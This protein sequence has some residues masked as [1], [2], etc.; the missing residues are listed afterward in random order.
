MGILKNFRRDF[1]QAVN[2]LLPESEGKASKKQKN[3]DETEYD[4]DDDYDYDYDVYEE[5]EPAEYERQEPRDVKAAVSEAILKEEADRMREELR[6][7]TE[8]IDQALDEEIESMPDGAGEYA[9]YEKAYPGEELSAEQ[10]ADSA[11][12]TGPEDAPGYDEEAVSPE[13]EDGAAEEGGIQ[14]YED[15]S[16][17][18]G[19]QEYEDGTDEEAAFSGDQAE[20]G[21]S[22]TDEEYDE[23]EEAYAGE[24]AVGFGENDTSVGEAVD[25]GEYDTSVG[26]T[27]TTGEYD[28]AGEET[29]ISSDE[30]DTADAES[31]GNAAENDEA[32]SHEME[33]LEAKER[34]KEYM[35]ELERV[36][37]LEDPISGLAADCTYITAKTKIRGDI[38]TEG[39]IDLIGEVTG[40]VTCAGKLIAGGIIHGNVKAGEL[41]ANQARIEGEVRADG[42]IKV[43]IGT[44]IL[45]NIFGTSA[46]IA[47][48]VQGDIDVN[49][50]VIVDSSAV[51]VGNIKSKSVQINNG[52]II[53]G[54]CSQAYLDVDVKKYFPDAIKKTEAEEKKEA[55]AEEAAAEDNAEAVTEEADAGEE[56]EE[57]EEP[58]AASDPGETEVTAEEAAEQSM[59]EKGQNNNR[60]RNNNKGKNHQNR[61]NR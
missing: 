49:G 16:G 6:A 26:E 4:Y 33:E 35:A 18:A 1:A 59:E 8:Q 29:E 58:A 23:A 56:R 43:G 38:E 46:V 44:V 5:E 54:F 3:K 34:K 9:G 17:E 31:E 14:E 45:G 30:A 32:L 22:G 21:V 53:E 28:T 61:K 41:Y 48:A 27:V 20:A 52:A 60:N 13:Y 11:F 36:A 47:G 37:G 42:D 25:S 50:P 12:M 57:T 2:E 55:P 51:I 39:D 19:I 7:S 10:Y 15:G 24:E 40:T